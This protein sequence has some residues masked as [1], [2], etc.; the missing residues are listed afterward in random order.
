MSY[1]RHKLSAQIERLMRADPTRTDRDILA[2]IGVI[3][4]SRLL[5]ITRCM[6]IR[7]GLA[8]RGKRAPYGPRKSLLKRDRIILRRVR[9]GESYR[10]I[11]RDYAPLTFQAIGCIVRRHKPKKP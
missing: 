3:P 5:N 7:L 10:A 6:R 9:A 1:P 8:V 2:L 4:S 11:A